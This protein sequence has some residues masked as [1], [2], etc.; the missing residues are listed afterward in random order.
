MAK[1]RI[2]GAYGKPFGKKA[3]VEISPAIMRQLGEC[4]VESF[5]AEA[6]KDFAKRGWS[7]QA[8][9]GNDPDGPPADGG[10]KLWDSFS[11]QIRGKSTLEILST[12]WGLKELMTGDIPKRRMVWL[13]QEYKDKHP[14]EFPLTPKER[15]LGMKQTGRVL[16][17][18]KGPARS[19]MTGQFAKRK[20]GRLPLVVPVQAGGT[21]V[22]RTAPLKL[23]DAWVHPGI[24]KFT[25][26]QRA[27][28]KGRR[29]C[30]EILSRE[31]V[32]QA[33]GG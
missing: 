6:K 11:Y 2:R 29:K 25:F 23:N 31:A 16:S 30:I 3:K 15:K 20:N 14:A 32:R 28:N 7:G 19:L 10:P 27:L 33:L 5:I 4:M 17:S 22:F 9:H 1:M 13:T 21:V 18:K 12:F 26:M 8:P 24:A